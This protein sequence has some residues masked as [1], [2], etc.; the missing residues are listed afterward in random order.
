MR[1]IK[2]L[3]LFRKSI[4][5]SEQTSLGGI[6]TLIALSS[7]GILFF[8]EISYYFENTINKETMIDQDRGAKLLPINLN[9]TLFRS[10][11]LTV[12]LDQLDSLGNHVVDVGG[13]LTKTRLDKNGNR[14]TEKLPN[15]DIS[16]A[17]KMIEEEEGCELSGNF[18]VTKTPGNFHISFHAT[19]Q[20]MTS[21]PRQTLSKVRLSHRINHLSYGKEQRNHYIHSIFGNG[22][23][24]NF[25]PYDGLEKNDA[26]GQVIKYEYNIKVI[27]V[28]Y[29]DESSG[30]ELNS[31]QYSMV[32]S[33]EPF[34]SV[35]G[36]IYFRYDVDGITMRYT[37]VTKSLPSLLVSMSAIL[38][39][40]FAVLGI[41]HSVMQEAIRKAK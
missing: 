12:S 3:D 22:E 34:N 26:P 40:I 21:I 11:C 5:I 8:S 30:E 18:S 10:P 4:G 13:A 15:L 35:F 17:I 23:Q 39:G 41:I 25:A 32:G 28:Q 36:I 24:T 14:I 19:H 6:I 1:N 37:R 16:N 27:P 9:I 20:I 7:M 29:Y 2:G 38:G 33:N 31:Y